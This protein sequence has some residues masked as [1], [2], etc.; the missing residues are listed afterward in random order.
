M[1]KIIVDSGSDISQ[2]GAEGLG[3]I[4]LPLEVAFGEKSYQDGISLSGEA[5]YEKLSSCKGF[6]KTSQ[7]NSFAY[8]EAF[9][10]EIA[11]GNEV[12]C[13][14]LS[15]K[16]SGCYQSANFAKGSMKGK[17][18][19]VD[20]ENVSL[21]EA[22]LVK[23]ALFYIKKGLSLEELVSKL[24]ALRKRV[25][26][27]ALLD[28]LEFL[29]RSGRISKAVAFLGEALGFKPIVSVKDGEVAL[30]G[31]T[32]G[33]KSAPLAMKK[34][35]DKCGGIDEGLPSGAAFGGAPKEDFSSFL[36]RIGFKIVGN[37]NTPYQIGAAIGSH[38]GPGAMEIAFF[39]K[40]V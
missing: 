17:I 24:T 14:T 2:E 20:T 13:L 19:V 37:K 3:I 18:E 33:R 7:I 8:Q 25:K 16:L 31:K 12:L 23:A 21:G 28:T 30:A 6:P 32:L 11:Q 15:G 22:I 29:R 35:I 5:F 1:I 34:L 38:V 39:A 40:G 4:V 27:F 9:E 26:V 10:K 36:V